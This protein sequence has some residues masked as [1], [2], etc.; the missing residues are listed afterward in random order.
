MLRGVKLVYINEIFR[1]VDEIFEYFISK[2]NLT[3]ASRTNQL[4][5]VFIVKRE[6]VVSVHFLTNGDIS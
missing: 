1:C 2:S 4:N 5:V 6:T 3:K